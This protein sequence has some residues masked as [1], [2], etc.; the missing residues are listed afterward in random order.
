MKKLEKLAHTL[1]DL[2]AAEIPLRQKVTAGPDGDWGE[3]EKGIA[4][5]R[6]KQDEARAALRVEIERVAQ[7]HAESSQAH[8]TVWRERELAGF[9]HVQERVKAIEKERDYALYQYGGA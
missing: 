2:Y 5:L 7:A 8:W 3:Y 4:E 1:A 6:P 9:V